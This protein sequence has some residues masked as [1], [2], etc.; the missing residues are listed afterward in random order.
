MS[1]TRGGLGRLVAMVL[2][3]M[4]LLFLALA[5]EARA[6]FYGVAQCGWGVGADADWWDST[7]GAKFRPEVGCS[8]HLKSFTRG[9]AGTVTGERFAR[10]RWVA[11]PTTSIRS[12]Q[13]SW[14]HTLN[15]GFQDRVGAATLAGDFSPFAVAGTTYSPT[16]IATTFTPS[17]PAVEDRLLCARGDDKWCTLDPESWASVREVV[18]TIDDGV[19]PGAWITGGDLTDG[20]WRRGGQSVA[21]AGYDAGSGAALG[22]TTVDGGQVGLQRYPCATV[23]TGSGELAARMQPCPTEAAGT[24]AID[25]TRFSDGAHTLGHCEQ[26]FAGN[27]ACAPGRGILIDNNAPAAP[28]S[29][30]VAGG[31]GWRRTNAFDLSWV[32]PD[33]GAASPI[34]GAYLRLLGPGGYDSLYRN[35]AAGTGI[36]KVDG[37]SVP[38][39]GE[40]EAWVWLRDEAGNEDPTHL[41]G[42]YLRFDAE[43]PKVAFDGREGDEDRDP[44]GQI[45]APASDRLSGPAGGTISYRRADAPNFTELP[46]KLRQGDDGKTALVA[47]T[48]TLGPGTWLFRAEAIDAAGN[49]ATTTLRGDGTQMSL[50]VKASAAGGGGKGDDRKDAGAGKDGGGDRDCRAR[51]PAS[52]RRAKAAGRG[53]AAVCGGAVGGA[54]A[55]RT[56][57]RLFVRLRGGHGSGD[58]VTVPFG[59]SALLAG[60]LTS[61]GGAGLAGR[62]IKVVTRPSHGALARRSVQRV[63]TGKRGGF[64]LRLAAGTSRR[65]SVS[66]GGQGELAPAGPRSLDLRVRAGVTLVAA[67]PTLDTRQSLRLSGQVRSRAAPIPRRGKLV[68]V[69]YLEAETDRW[70]PVLVT[71]TDHGGR[72]HARYRFRYVSGAARIRLRATALAEERWPYAPG[73]SA[74]VTVTVSGG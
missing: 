42:V 5:G 40:W 69:Q 73:S 54:A 13:A 4:A 32:D 65:I 39:E 16:E 20:G 41:A 52:G 50:H 14:W 62:T 45:V 48:P 43:P 61:A 27:R 21:F 51:R 17:V 30:R 23:G 56:K 64:G 31:E 63:R 37:A 28:S 2:A 71:R 67:P 53:R 11:P 24:L 12:F 7:G 36:A 25:T 33:Q 22:E 18:L 29:L 47:P 55:R 49:V 19:P 1:G 74:P 58:A 15:D 9:G 68:A 6:G 10:W 35:Y 26:D 72:F 66:F 44:P 3:L 38:D 70:R 60:R 8:D 46:T 59:A 57:T 34:A